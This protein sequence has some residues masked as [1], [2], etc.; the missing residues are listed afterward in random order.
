M[1]HVVGEYFPIEA[2][3]QAVIISG[4]DNWMLEILLKSLS[5]ALWF[6]PVP[7]K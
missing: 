7:L 2:A 3:H 4:G 1:A 6:S 5:R